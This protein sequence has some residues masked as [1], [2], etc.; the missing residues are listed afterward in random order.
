MVQ[1]W[2]LQVKNIAIVALIVLILPVAGCGADRS[3]R[4][5]KGIEKIS[6]LSPDGATRAFVWMPTMGET[7]GA[8]VSQVVE[9]WLKGVGDIRDEKRILTADK[10]DGFEIR[11]R[12]PKYLDVCYIDGQIVA[13]RNMINL[14]SVEMQ[15]SYRIEVEL[16]KVSNLED[17]KSRQER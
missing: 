12:G 8:T 14:V 7:L 4:S 10:T 16:K 9:V 6:V 5:E 1:L 13:Y 2:V 17:C 11:W 3:K 15:K